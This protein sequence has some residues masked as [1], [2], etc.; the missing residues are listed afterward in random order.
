MDSTVGII[1]QKIKEG[2]A[3]M[4]VCEMKDCNNHELLYK[5]TDGFICWSCVNRVFKA[6]NRLEIY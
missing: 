1:E 6:L 4:G 2:K 5:V 3:K